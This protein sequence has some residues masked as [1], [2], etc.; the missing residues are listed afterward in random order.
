MPKRARELGP[1]DVKRL[2]RP[3]LHAVGGVAGLTLQITATGARSWLFRYRFNGRRREAGLGPFPDVPLAKARD[4]AREARDLLWQ[5]IDP[6]DHRQ[7]ARTQ[8]QTLAE[9]VGLFA[10]KKAIEF[11]SAVHRKQWRASIERHVLPV[12]G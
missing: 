9:A 12:L 11:R 7:A 5:G 2:T 10:E 8:Q 3:G 6:I 4:Y 1:L